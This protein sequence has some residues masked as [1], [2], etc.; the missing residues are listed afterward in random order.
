MAAITT[1]HGSAHSGRPALLARYRTL[2]DARHAIRDLE[3]RGIDGDDI[4][5]VGAASVA[6]RT[7]DRSRI[8]RRMLTSTTAALAIGIVGGGL[9]GALLGAVVMGIVVLAFSVPSE[10]WVFTLMVCWFAAA[11][12]LFASL[13]SVMR[14]L[15]FS[16]SVPLTWEDEPPAPVWL[17][18][19]GTPREVRP[20]V[21]ATQPAEIVDD[22]SVT[23]HP[24]ELVRRAS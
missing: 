16:E 4:S 17:A 23:A 9:A 1:P 2:V 5:L 19:Y 21:E 18:V 15:G 3:T 7:T 20:D 8:D 14:T 22:P 10:G 6:E 24:D 13:A 11:G 12:S